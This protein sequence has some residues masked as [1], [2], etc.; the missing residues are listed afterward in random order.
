MSAPAMRKRAGPMPTWARTAA[1]VSVVYEGRRPVQVHA[2]DGKPETVLQGQIEH[3]QPMAI[4]GRSVGF[5]G[6]AL[7]RNKPDLV[8]VTRRSHLVGEC[9]VA[10]VYRIEGPAK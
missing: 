8:Q 9:Q 1:T 2:G 3:S 5:Q 7:R 6:R 4:T 10:V